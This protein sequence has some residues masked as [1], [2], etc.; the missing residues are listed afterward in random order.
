MKIKKI[1]F[2]SSKDRAMRQ[3]S[4]KFIPWEEPQVY[5]VMNYTPELLTP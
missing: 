1:N 3:I 2:F 5:E 4:D